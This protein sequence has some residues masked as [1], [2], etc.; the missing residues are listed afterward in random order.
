MHPLKCIGTKVM[1]R[2]Y[3]YLCSN[4]GSKKGVGRINSKNVFLYFPPLNTIQPNTQLVDTCCAECNSNSKKEN[5]LK[6]NNYTNQGRA[7]LAS[8]YTI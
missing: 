1:N 5:I 7:L 2:K 8:I 6:Q 3:R 4:V